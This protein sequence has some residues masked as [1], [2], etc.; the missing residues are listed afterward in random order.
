MDPFGILIIACGTAFA[1]GIVR[2]LMLN[3]HPMVWVGR[4]KYLIITCSAALLVLLIR[5]WIRYM[6]EA[7]LILDAIGLITFSII[8]TQKTLELGHG[9]IIAA[10]RAFFTGAFGASFGIFFVTRQ[11]WFFAK[12]SMA[13]LHFFL[14]SCI[15]VWQ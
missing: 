14:P 15:S 4:P 13:A 9:Y 12:S 1:G 3:N 11:P 10:I 2:D 6:T 5:P 7:F 8:G